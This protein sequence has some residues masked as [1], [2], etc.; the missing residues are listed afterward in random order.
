MVSTIQYWSALMR[1]ILNAVY[2]CP[3]KRNKKIILENML[4]TGYA[5]E[6]KALA[7]WME[8]DFYLRGCARRYGGC[9][10]YAKNKK[11]WAEGRG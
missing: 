9:T 2:F 11:D 1:S 7:R 10:A 5:A 4:I 3:V 8:S 6:G